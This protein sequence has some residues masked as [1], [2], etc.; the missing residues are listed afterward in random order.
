MP[1][2]REVFAVPEF[3]PLFAASA[4]AIA[5]VT[6]EGLALATLVYAATRSPLLAALAM[7]GS[8]FAQVIGAATLLSVADRMPPRA[9]LTGLGLLFTAAALALAIPGVPVWG[10]LAIT[11]AAGLAASAYGGAQ[12]GL[13]SEILPAD[14]YILGRSLFNMSVG[15]MQILGYAAGGA[16]VGLVSPRGALLVAAALYLASS[17]ATWLGLSSRR[18]RV[19]GRPSVR[20]TLRVNHRLWSRPA[21]RY[22]YLALWVPNGLIVGC[23]ALFIPYAPRRASLLFIAAAA[24]MLAGDTVMGRLV[25]A[26]WRARLAMPLRL[27][28]AVPYLLFA[29]RLPLPAAVAA[30]A[31]ASV[32]YSASLLLQ[33]RLLAVTPDDLHGQALGL[34]SSGML[35]MQ[36][37]GAALAGALAQW[38]PPADVMTVLAVAS[39]AVTLALTPG[40]GHH[41]SPL[42]ST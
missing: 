4:A 14:R 38:L 28:L 23:E 27:L 35:T 39:V 20:A 29:L 19:A 18:P 12:W 22:A 41:R 2:Y 42:V 1:S 5:G 24:G 17:A 34:H 21:R 6:V 15:V 3:R 8:S 31:V 11:L 33:D 10:L 16:L 13:V 40:L 32:G 9:T 25:P 36:A 30:V 7:F 26:T 37:V